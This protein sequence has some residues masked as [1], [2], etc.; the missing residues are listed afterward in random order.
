[1]TVTDQFK[2]IDNKIKANQAQCDLDR[3]AAKISAYSSGDL[4]KYEYLT[5]E[6]LGYRPSVSEQVRFNYFLLGNIFTKGLD[7]D[8]RKE[9]LFQ[10]LRN[11]EDKK[12]RA[13]KRNQK[14]KELSNKISQT[15]KA[16]NLLIY[17]QNHNFNKWKLEKFSNISI[18]SKFSTLEMFYREFIS[19]KNLD[20]KT[21]ENIDYKFVV[22]NRALKEYDELIK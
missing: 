20:P 13:V 22:L 10:R 7:K 19:L 4:R 15:A 12:R 18:E 16:K 2:V 17:D 21:E 6:D 14:T 1:M 8:D 9:G 11:I 5:G 3:S